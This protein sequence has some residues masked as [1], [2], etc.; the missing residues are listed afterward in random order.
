MFSWT[1]NFNY[2]VWEDSVLVTEGKMVSSDWWASSSKKNCSFSYKESSKL[3]AYSN[4]AT[5]I[6]QTV[7]NL[8]HTITG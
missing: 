1:L 2:F 5:G 4:L 8:I 6:C 7:G 3:K